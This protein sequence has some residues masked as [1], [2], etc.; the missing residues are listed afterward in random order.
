MAPTEK[1]SKLPNCDA[2]FEAIQLKKK[3]PYALQ[4][5]LTSAFAQIP[6]SSFPEVPGGKVIEVPGDMSIV[7]A[8]RILS[9]HHIMTAPV[10]HPNGENSID[11]RERY[12][13][14]I[15]YAAIILWVLENA[16]LAAITLSAS[17][18]TATGVGAGAVGALGAAVLGATG[19]AAVAGLTIAAVGAA[20]AGGV[21]TEKGMGKDAPSS[22]NHLGE[23][24]YKTLLEEEP[25]KSTT[26]K[27]IMES[28]RWAPFLPVGLDSSM[29][30]VLLLL[31]K[32]RLR[33]VPVV[34]SGKPHVTN[35]ITQTAVVQ[36]LQQCAGRDWFDCIAAYPLSDLGLPFMSSEEVISIKSDDLILEA[37]K[38]MKDNRIGGLPVVEG[39]N[40]KI[41]GSVSIRDIRFLL[42]KPG[43]FS[44]FR[45]LTVMDFLRTLDLVSQDSRNHAVAPV[46]CAPDACL[47]SVIDSLASKSVHRIYVVEGDEKEVVGVIT[48]RDVISCFIYEPPYHFDTYFGCAVKEL[49]S[50]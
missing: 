23:A 15:D 38:C 48:L 9:E 22:V 30:T 11:W 20:I 34:E 1:S 26:V 50:R 39:P 19:P 29:L 14:I 42:L 21:A 28:Y 27:S 24:F 35:F 40:Q 31:S 44:N 5:C 4:E 16:E 36:G 32:Y 12:L 2:Y 47:G 7:D 13:G 10:T 37:F 46:T 49:Q 3:L 17:S 25:F 8:V 41:V 45:Q 43:L 33:S 6:V 18:A